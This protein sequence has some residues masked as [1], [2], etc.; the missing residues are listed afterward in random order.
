MMYEMWT[1]SQ[2]REI[3][4]R[5]CFGPWLHFKLERSGWSQAPF[6]CRK[7]VFLWLGC[8]VVGEVRTGLNIWSCENSG[9]PRLVCFESVQTPEPCEYS[10]EKV[11]HESE[12]G[13]QYRPTHPDLAGLSPKFVPLGV[14]HQMSMFGTWGETVSDVEQRKSISWVVMFMLDT[15]GRVSIEG[16]PTFNICT[17]I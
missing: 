7:F 9:S 17:N 8:L 5:H 2:F 12:T 16:F 15:S 10:S 6:F 14:I 13:I 3:S 1:E 11:S 4:L